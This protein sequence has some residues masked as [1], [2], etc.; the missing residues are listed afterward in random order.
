MLVTPAG[1]VHGVEPQETR[2]DSAE[3]GLEDTEGEVLHLHL[4]LSII[5][6]QRLLLSESPR[7]LP[8]RHTSATELERPLKQASLVFSRR[9]T[10][11]S[12]VH[13][14]K[15]VCPP[16]GLSIYL[17]VFILLL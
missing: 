14:S 2:R 4:L 12:R 9:S 3:N 1:A 8:F 17:D 10:G 6:T 11:C 15:M 7:R 5:L 16:V 13:D